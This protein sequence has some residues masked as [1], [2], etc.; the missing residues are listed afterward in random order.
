[1]KSR[2][3]RSRNL[4]R[5][6]TEEAIFAFAI[7]F[8]GT[9][10]LLFILFIFAKITP[11]TLPR[12]YQTLEAVT[13]TQFVMPL[14]L[15]QP[16]P[17]PTATYTFQTTETNTPTTTASVVQTSTITPTETITPTP[18]LN[19]G[20]AS[21][22]LIGSSSGNK[23]IQVARFGSGPIERLIVA[24]IHGGY[25]ANTVELAR[26]L[27]EY[28]KANPGEIPPDKTLYILPVLNP[29]GYAL[30]FG[31]QGRLNDNGVD[32]NRNFNAF[33][34]NAWSTTN[35]W[36]SLPVSAGTSPESELETQALV[37]FIKAHPAI[38]ALISYHSAGLGIFAGGQPAD[39]ASQNLAQALSEVSSYPY[40]PVNNGCQYTGQL[41]DWAISQGIAAVDVE[42]NTH[43]QIEFDENLLIL[44][45]FLSWS[46]P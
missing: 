18:K 27:I 29:D 3:L 2:N 30:G 10:S 6:R 34:T 33:W 42:L 13:Q 15:T 26:A 25:E 40:P 21:L 41:I 17:F 44:Q 5:I 20:N 35:C 16:S 22:L 23:P 4:H 7:G 46:K 24:G 39:L 12:R 43:E 32:L 38:D 14:L 11:P 28:L 1:M 19:Q 9:L 31:D 8:L 37:Q 36:N 45:R